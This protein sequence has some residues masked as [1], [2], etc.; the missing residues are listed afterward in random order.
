MSLG[1]PQRQ[2]VGSRG[3]E[4]GVELCC[5][6][7]SVKKCRPPNLINVSFHYTDM[8]SLTHGENQLNLEETSQQCQT[9][10]PSSVAPDDR[11][12]QAKLYQGWKK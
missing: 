9:E 5:G 12:Y 4:C 1:V 3:I 7:V 6:V 11:V 8:N 10:Y 2:N